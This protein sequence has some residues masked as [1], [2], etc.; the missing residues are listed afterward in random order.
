MKLLFEFRQRAR[1]IVWPILWA[2]LM[3]YITFHALQGER[4]LIAYWQ[5]R[6]EISEARQVQTM[7][8][9]TKSRIQ[10]RVDLLTSESLDTDLLEE[11]ARLLL[12]YSQPDEMIILVK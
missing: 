8:N 3:L 6:G 1:H 12:G 4:G 2:T 7:L 11:R 9:R 10:K 5:I